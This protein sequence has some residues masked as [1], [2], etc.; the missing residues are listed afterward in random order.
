VAYGSALGTAGRLPEA[1]DLLGRAVA[2]SPPERLANALQRHAL[3]LA[4]LAA[5]ESVILAENGSNNCKITVQI[6]QE[7][8]Q[9]AANDST[10]SQYRPRLQG[11]LER[12]IGNTRFTAFPDQL[13]L[14]NPFF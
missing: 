8:Q 13:G 7:W 11:P 12:G 2:L 9:T 3:S 5:G 14:F 6:P 10:K 4:E 1:E